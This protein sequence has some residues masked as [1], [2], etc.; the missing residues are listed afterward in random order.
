[1]L[2]PHHLLCDSYSLSVGLV[3]LEEKYIA[4]QGKKI[5]SHSR[6]FSRHTECSQPSMYM[7]DTAEANITRSRDLCASWNLLNLGSPS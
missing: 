3:R 7:P 2:K 5:F 4:W 1:M 6:P